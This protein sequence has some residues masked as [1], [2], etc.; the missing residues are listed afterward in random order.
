MTVVVAAGALVV[1]V[2][3][4]C[5]ADTVWSD[6]CSPSC[7]LTSCSAYALVLM[8]A[9]E[10]SASPEL[11]CSAARSSRSGPRCVGGVALS[12]A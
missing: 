2:L 3:V 9:L 1:A 6:C 5:A 11:A 12:A 4:T 10:I 8:L 7:R